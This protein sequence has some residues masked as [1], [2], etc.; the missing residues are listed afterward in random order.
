MSSWSCLV[1]FARLCRAAVQRPAQH[2]LGQLARKAM[3]HLL[4][5]ARRR[6]ELAFYFRA[7]LFERLACFRFRRF[8]HLCGLGFGLA[9]FALAPRECALSEFGEA[10]FALRFGLARLLDQQLGPIVQVLESA[11]ALR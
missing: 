3:S 1:V 2:A 7:H 9:P 4:K 11:L 8:H 5:L 6:L 10:L